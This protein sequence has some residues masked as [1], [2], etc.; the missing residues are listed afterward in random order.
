[1]TKRQNDKKTKGQKG[2]KTKGQKDKKTKKKTKDKDQKEKSG[3]F[4]TLAIFFNMFCF[5]ILH[6]TL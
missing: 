5:A 2:E 4:R 6:M 3:Q 1:M